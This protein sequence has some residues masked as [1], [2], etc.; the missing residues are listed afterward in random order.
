MCTLYYV[1]P[2]TICSPTPCVSYTMCTLYHVYPALQLPKLTSGLGLHNLT[3]GSIPLVASIQCDG[4]GCRQL[5]MESSPLSTRSML[6]VQRSHRKKEPSSDPATMYW[7]LLHWERHT[8]TKTKQN[9]ILSCS[10]YWGVPSRTA[11]G[12]N[13]LKALLCSHFQHSQDLD[14]NK[15]DSWPHHLKCARFA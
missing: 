3:T 11:A 7:P 2:Y 10:V 1:L 8:H 15:S 12:E 4:W 9:I 13:I 6:V 5:T 14:G